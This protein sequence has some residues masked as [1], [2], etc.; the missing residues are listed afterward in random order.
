MKL[1]FVCVCVY[2]LAGQA[3][4]KVGQ[5]Q[6]LLFRAGLLSVFLGLGLAQVSLFIQRFKALHTHQEGQMQ[7]VT[8]CYHF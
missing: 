1:G 8:G 2:L 6:L 4:D 3:L 7:V 5:A